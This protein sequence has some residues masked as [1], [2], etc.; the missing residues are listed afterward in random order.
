MAEELSHL[1]SAKASLKFGVGVPPPL[2]KR[3]YPQLWVDGTIGTEFSQERICGVQSDREKIQSNTSKEVRLMGATLLTHLRN[4]PVTPFNFASGAVRHN[5]GFG[6]SSSSWVISGQV[7]VKHI[8][9]S[10]FITL[11]IPS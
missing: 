9:N 3:L 2:K 5:A 10:P 7:V 4:A 8:S 6:R 1:L 11:L